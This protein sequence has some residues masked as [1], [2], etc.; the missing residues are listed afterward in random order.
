MYE[1]LALVLDAEGGPLSELTLSLISLGLSPLY[2]RNLDELVLLSREYRGRVGAVLVPTDRIEEQVGAIL[3]RIVEP[4]G[5]PAASVVP[6][7]SPLDSKGA[8]ALADQGLRWALWRPFEAPDLR[9]VVAHALSNS[10]PEELRL[11]AR[12]PCSLPAQVESPLRKAEVLLTDLSPGGCFA[13]LAQPYPKDAR[14]RLRCELALQPVSIG[15]RVAW[16]TG[17]DRPDWQQGGMGVEFLE[18]ENDAR[19]SLT[20]QVGERFARYRIGAPRARTQ[21]R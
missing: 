17:P 12:I 9:F 19:E 18:M 1:R 8:E 7:G 6:V 20:R 10:D 16:S 3:E 4:L 15:C 5:L 11:H 14:I 21:A 13:R 2:S